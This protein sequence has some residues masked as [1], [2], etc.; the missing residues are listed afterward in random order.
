LGLSNPTPKRNRRRVS[1]EELLCVIQNASNMAEHVENTT[2]A[3]HGA[4]PADEPLYAIHS[5]RRATKRGLRARD[6]QS[7]RSSSPLLSSMAEAPPCAPNR[8]RTMNQTQDRRLPV[9]KVKALPLLRE[10]KNKRSPDAIGWSNQRLGRRN[11]MQFAP[12]S[13]SGCEAT[14][15]Q[16]AAE[17]ASYQFGCHPGGGNGGSVGPWTASLSSFEDAAPG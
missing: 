6:E 12:Q 15:V 9:I 17:H 14:H 2:T 8:R 13:S 3:D 1:H 5:I 16:R 4:L 11:S 10:E 7:F